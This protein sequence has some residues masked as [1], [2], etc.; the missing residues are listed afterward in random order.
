MYGLPSIQECVPDGGVFALVI[1][2]I[3][4]LLLA[5]EAL[6]LLVIGTRALK[7]RADLLRVRDLLIEGS[8]GQAILFSDRRQQDDVLAVCRAGIVEVQSSGDRTNAS[9]RIAQE[10]GFRFATTLG[11]K[12]RLVALTLI[13]LVPVGLALTGRAYAEK[14]AREAAAEIPEDQRA[15]VL[16][17]VRGDPPFGCPY[18]LGFTAA[19]A[20]ALPAAAIG[21]LEAARRSQATR[22]RA[23]SQAEVFADMAA[24][25][26]N[27]STRAYREDRR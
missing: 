3:A 8:I 14:V 5:I 15:S 13:A 18:T 6:W 7:R 9:E 21:F 11:T 16:D 22:R 1:P 17:Q 23:V 20:L 26:I 19:I 25:V 10:A 2:P 27:P 24:V 4:G 12:V